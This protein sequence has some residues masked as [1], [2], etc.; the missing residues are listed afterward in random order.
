MVVL[1]LE[2]L[3]RVY[4]TWVALAVVAARML[5]MLKPAHRGRLLFNGPSREGLLISMEGIGHYRAG[6]AHEAA[7]QAPRQDSQRGAP[8]YP[9]LLHHPNT[10]VVVV[11]MQVMA[12]LEP[13]VREARF[14]AEAEA[15]AVGAT[16][17]VLFHPTLGAGIILTV[18]LPLTSLAAQPE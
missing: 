6:V 7:D 4:I 18:L 10:V 11:D 14:M 15:A 2:P 12:I 8:P 1:T 3:L 5:H 9:P 16:T 17:P 13:V